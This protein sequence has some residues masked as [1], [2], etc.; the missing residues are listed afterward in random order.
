VKT[1]RFSFSLPEELI[2]QEPAPDRESARL[3]VLERATGR[4]E[5]SAVRDLAA[6]IEPGTL[7]VLNDSRVRKARLIGESASGRRVEL[8][9]LERLP[10]G[11]WKAIAG[12]LRRRDSSKPLRFAEGVAAAF[13]GAEGAPATRSAARCRAEGD[14]RVVRFEPPVDEAYLERRGHVPLPPYIRR[15]DTGADAERYQTV[16]ARRTGSAAAPTA[17]LHFTGRLLAELEAKGVHTTY[18]TL[19]VGLGTF[20]PIRS[21]DIEG[22][23][24]HEEAYTVTPEAKMA[25]G[26]AKAEGRRI[27][28]VGTTV[29]RTLESAWDGSCLQEGEGRTR[30]FIT[31]GYRFR[32]ID[33]LFTNFHT[34]GSSLLVL[35][36][37]FAGLDLILEAYR[38]AVDQRYRFFSY[39]DA[40]L[41]L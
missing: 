9:L 10:D 26:S 21:E 36:S 27:L 15:A 35:V 33:A 31:P 38:R 30:L 1:S 28:A 11:T 39:G 14:E 16:F 24:M 37:A 19:H 34:P 18:V 29:A 41:I 20:L 13:I 6:W 17:G 3:L 25:V 32:A 12:G 8:L 2:A 7:V 5:H 40:M 22:H 4:V 23:V